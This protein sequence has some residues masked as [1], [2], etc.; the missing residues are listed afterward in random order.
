MVRNDVMVGVGCHVKMSSAM[1]ELVNTM[2]VRE[3]QK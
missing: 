2:D 3:L 1:P